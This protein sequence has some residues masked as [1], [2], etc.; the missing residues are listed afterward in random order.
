MNSFEKRYITLLTEAPSTFLTPTSFTLCTA[1]NETNP[2]KP[3]QLRKMAITAKIL[4]RLD[5]WLSCL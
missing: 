4:Y 2:Y 1:M 5:N 3:R